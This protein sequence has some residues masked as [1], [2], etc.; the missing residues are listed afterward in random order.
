MVR[1]PQQQRLLVQRPHRRRHRLCEPTPPVFSSA[2]PMLITASPCRAAR[3]T[4]TAPSGSRARRSRAARRARDRGSSRG[5]GQVSRRSR[6][7]SST[8]HLLTSRPR[9]TATSTAC[10]SSG[11]R[12]S[13][14]TTRCP[15]S[16]WVR[17]L[18]FLSACLRDAAPPRADARPT[19][20]FAHSRHSRARTAL[21]Q[22]VARHLPGPHS[23][24]PVLASQA[25]LPCSS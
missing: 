24:S 13:R 10:T 16:T 25:A 1:R 22:R 17:L 7:S 19:P 5:K 2:L 12:S 3:S 6:R 8:R 4:A 14:Q 11:A 20:L 23:L 21:E 15:S 9:Q 18:L